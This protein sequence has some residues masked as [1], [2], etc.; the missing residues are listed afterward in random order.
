MTLPAA[1]LI[2]TLSAGDSKRDFTFADSELRR[3]EARGGR[4]PPTIALIAGGSLIAVGI[5]FWSLA[6]YT[7]WQ[8]RTG[9]ADATSTQEVGRM[10]RSGRNLER[11]GWAAGALGLV[12][13]GVAGVLHLTAPSDA[14]PAA[15]FVPA[16]GGG[17]VAI[18]GTF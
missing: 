8:L 17:L 11:V 2:S 16:A 18:A 7:E 9:A 5:T 10:V 13:L 4:S 15:A 6:K 3:G 1:V 14:R 12:G